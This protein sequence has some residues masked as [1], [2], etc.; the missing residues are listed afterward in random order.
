LIKVGDGI[1]ISRIIAAILLFVAIGRHPMDNTILRFLVCEVAAYAAH[2]AKELKKDDWV[3]TFGI[4]VLLFNSFI[5]TRPV[6]GH[7]AIIYLV[8]AVLLLI[9]FSTETITLTDVKIKFS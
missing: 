9:V 8:V 5:P 6:R 1:Q 7:W 2:F 3:S 4:I